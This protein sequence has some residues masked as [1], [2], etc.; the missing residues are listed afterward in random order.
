M[1]FSAPEARAREKKTKNARYDLFRK[2]ERKKE[3]KM[4]LILLL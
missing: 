1:Y 2:E 3:R 4:S